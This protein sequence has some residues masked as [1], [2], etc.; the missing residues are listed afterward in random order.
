[1][2]HG[3]A[4]PAAPVARNLG[5]YPGKGGA[6]PFVNFLNEGWLSRVVQKAAGRS[7][8]TLS[9]LLRS[10]APTTTAAP[11]PITLKAP[12]APRPIALG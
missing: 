12:S 11:P 2:A 4:N 6:V 9:F 7:F 8:A 3:N 5:N 1:M 10:G